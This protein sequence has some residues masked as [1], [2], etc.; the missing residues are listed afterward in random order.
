MPT[1][2]SLLGTPGNLF[3]WAAAALFVSSFFCLPCSAQPTNYQR[4][5]S[6][7]PTRQSG[8]APRG[9][10]L[11]GFDGFLYG[12]TYAGGSSNLGT[13]FKLSRQGANFTVLHSFSDG[14][15][16]YAGLIQDSDGTLY[17]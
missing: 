6:F 3:I 9:R 16:P 8:I 14:E 15:F 11:Q 1:R 4:L 5:L 12:T 13:V 17:G 10:L 2:K 7:G